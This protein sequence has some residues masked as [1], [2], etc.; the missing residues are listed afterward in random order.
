VNYTRDEL[1]EVFERI[2]AMKRRSG[3]P[4]VN[5]HES[6]AEMQRHLR[7]EREQFGCLGGFKYFYLDWKLDLYRCHYWE[8][9][10]CNIRDFDASKLIRDGCTRCM[11]DCYRDPSVLQ[12]AAV[13]VHDA[14]QNLKRGKLLA[15]AG[16]LLDRRN[17]TSLKAV[18]ED[19]K[20][21]GGV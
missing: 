9:P 15:A 11:I 8:T 17:V 5:P 10:M 12:F 13:S 20:Y 19:R 4:V 7:G 3:F 18:W 16:N 14:W 21:I 2:K 6:L 1:V